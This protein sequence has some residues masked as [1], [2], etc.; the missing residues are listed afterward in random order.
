MEL[1]NFCH[2]YI[3]SLL[4]NVDEFI[5]VSNIHHQIL[6]QKIT[7]LNTHRTRQFLHFESALGEGG[8]G[9]VF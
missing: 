2:S 4:L 7:N 1:S 8:G 5:Q 9:E 6:V 3:Q